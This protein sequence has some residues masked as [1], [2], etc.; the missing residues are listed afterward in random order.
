M[1]EGRGSEEPGGKGVSKDRSEFT[2]VGNEVA[3]YG[4]GGPFDGEELAA[5]GNKIT[6]GGDLISGGCNQ[7]V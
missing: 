4:N 6:A 1:V 5:Y 7:M 2:K 3:T